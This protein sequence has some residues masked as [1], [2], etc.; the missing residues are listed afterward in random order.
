MLLQFLVFFFGHPHTHYRRSVVVVVHVWLVVWWPEDIEE[1]SWGIA[2]P[3]AGSRMID[4][5][6]LNSLTGSGDLIG[7][8]YSIP[9]RSSLDSLL[10]SALFVTIAS[11]WFTSGKDT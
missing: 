11:H 3:S 6:V 4:S 10:A 5:K 2:V 8:N 1:T 9:R 7:S